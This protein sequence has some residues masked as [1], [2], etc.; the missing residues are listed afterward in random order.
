VNA[1]VERAAQMRGLEPW[2]VLHI[3]T[4]RPPARCRFG[5]VWVLRQMDVV[6]VDIAAQLGMSDRTSAYYARCMA[7]RFRLERPDFRQFT[8]DLLIFAKSIWPE[9]DAEAA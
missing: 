9:R 8:D 2:Q 1:I 3:T 4:K 5:I 6:Y 7:D